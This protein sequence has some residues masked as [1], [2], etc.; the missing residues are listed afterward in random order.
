MEAIGLTRVSVPSTLFK[1][2]AYVKHPV[3]GEG[4]IV[5]QHG[6]GSSAATFTLFIEALSQL[7]PKLGFIAYDL[8]HHGYTEPNDPLTVPIKITDLDIDTLCSDLHLIVT[9]LLNL[10]PAKGSEKPAIA[11]LGHSMG[12]TVVSKFNEVYE[13][14]YTMRGLTVIDAVEGYATKSLKS[15]PMLLEMWPERFA[16][17]DEAIKWSLYDSAQLRNKKSAGIS[18]PPL[19]VETPDGEGFEWKLDLKRTTLNWDTW[20][21]NLDNL[22]MSAKCGRLLILSGVSKLDT[23]LTRAQMQGKFQMCVAPEAGHYI[24]EDAPMKVAQVVCD[25]WERNSVVARIVPKFGKFRSD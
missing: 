7:N 2:N 16:S 18:I 22:F 21:K 8:R 4:Y 11:L 20:F 14:E 6:V 12:G 3:E 13:S 10:N 9:H 1:F 17:L 19:L 25:F 15:M 24:Q 23:D 5:C